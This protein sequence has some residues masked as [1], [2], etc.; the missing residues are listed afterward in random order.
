MERRSQSPLHTV[1]RSMMGCQTAQSSVPAQSGCS[2]MVLGNA[3]CEKSLEG[4]RGLKS[5]LL[6]FASGQ[7]LILDRTAGMQIALRAF[8]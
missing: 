3:A 7:I 8:V 1:L 5:L 2:C 6:I 4:S